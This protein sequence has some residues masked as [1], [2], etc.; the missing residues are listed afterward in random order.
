MVRA[1][2]SQ[3]VFENNV[4]NVS[5]IELVV[6]RE[7]LCLLIQQLLHQGYT[8][9]S[10]WLLLLKFIYKEARSLIS[11]NSNGE[12][13]DKLMKETAMFIKIQC[14][15]VY[16]TI[17]FAWTFTRH[18]RIWTNSYKDKGNSCIWKPFSLQISWIY[19]DRV[20]KEHYYCWNRQDVSVLKIL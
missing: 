6:F 8:P 18:L 11:V 3:M 14:H 10:T 1:L 15:E 19:I 2:R 5:I 4:I 17:A 13:I 9:V 20:R 12:G 16:L 7:Y